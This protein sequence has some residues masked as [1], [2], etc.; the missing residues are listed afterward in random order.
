MT[1]EKLGWTVAESPIG[2]LTVVAGRRG[3]TNVHFA[4]TVPRLPREAERPLPDAVGQLDDYF[5]GQRKAFELDLDPHGSPLQMAVWRQLLAIP[6]GAT[7]SYGE[8]ARGID[9]S[10]YELDL[11]PYRRARVV[12]AAVGRNPLPVLIACHR[13]IGADG[14][15][16]GYFGGLDRKRLLLELE[17]IQLAGAGK[18]QK[19]KLP[20]GQLAIL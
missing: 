1:S 3:I 10:L 5:A 2:P 14:S 18:V 19:P 17:G 11:E 7:T 16:T 20:E 13:V 6:Y 15:L 12:G 8:V 9:E 4:G